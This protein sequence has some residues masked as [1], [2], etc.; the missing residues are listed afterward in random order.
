M[1]RRR[2]GREVNIEVVRPVTDRGVAV[3]QAARDLDRAGSVLRRW[4]RDL[5]AVPAVALR[6]NRVSHRLARRDVVP[7]GPV[8]GTPPQDRVNGQLRPVIA[9]NHVG[10]A[11][12]LD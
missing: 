7:F 12:A 5:T 8:L 4:T 2:F 1:T 9:D 11:A 6:G 3:A 10:F